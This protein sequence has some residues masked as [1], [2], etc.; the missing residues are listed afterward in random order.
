MLTKTA[1]RRWSHIPSTMHRHYSIHGP[2]SYPRRSTTSASYFTHHGKA[3]LKTWQSK[4]QRRYKNN[5]RRN[6][7]PRR[8]SNAAK[9]CAG[10]RTR[11]KH[12]D[13]SLHPAEA[14]YEEPEAREE[15]Q[16]CVEPEVE[17]GQPQQPQLGLA[18]PRAIYQI[19]HQAWQAAVEHLALAGA[20]EQ[21]ED[22]LEARDNFDNCVVQ[23][24]L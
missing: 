2:V 23:L 11:K 12:G 18:Q 1:P 8:R 9:S 20:S 7:E 17:R 4:R 22:A 6:A 16:G 10:E 21:A 5:K 14:A 24:V 3:P 13:V 19:H 15:Q